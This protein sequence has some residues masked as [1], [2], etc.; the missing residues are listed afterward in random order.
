M[1]IVCLQLN[2]GVSHQHAS[3]TCERCEHLAKPEYF[4]TPELLEGGLAVIRANVANGTLRE[5]RPDARPALAGQPAFGALDEKHWPDVFVYKFR[6]STCG[7]RFELAGETYHGRGARWTQV[8]SIS[9]D[10]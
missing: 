9:P 5:E 4:S 8:G 1:V 10:G 7:S 3:M 2:L 6:C